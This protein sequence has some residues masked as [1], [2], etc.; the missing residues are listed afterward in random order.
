MSRPFGGGFFCMR[1]LDVRSIVQ[2]AGSKRNRPQHQAGF[3]KKS[4]VKDKNNAPY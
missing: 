3:Q 1:A 4:S 2:E